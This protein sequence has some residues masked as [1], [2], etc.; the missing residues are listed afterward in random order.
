VRTYPHQGL[1]DSFKK[2]HAPVKHIAAIATG[3]GMNHQL[4]EFF[5]AVYKRRIVG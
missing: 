4:I 5:L 2:G 1:R 3:F